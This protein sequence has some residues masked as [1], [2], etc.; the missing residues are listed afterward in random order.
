MLT[1]PMVIKVFCGLTQSFVIPLSLGWLSA[2][3]TPNNI[4]NYPRSGSGKN[5][6]Q[7]FHLIISLVV[8]LLHQAFTSVICPDML[9]SSLAEYFTSRRF[10]TIFPGER[11]S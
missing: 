7:S 6:S 4:D 9:G 2:I 5:G 3:F 1:Q 11:V 10:S 8:K